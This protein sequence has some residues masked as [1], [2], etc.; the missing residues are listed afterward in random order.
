V[1]LVPGSSVAVDL[2]VTHTDAVLARPT[3]MTF[4]AA[5][6]LAVTLPVLRMCVVP[7]GHLPCDGAFL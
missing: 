5:P 6:V 7:A 2:L 4:A 3:L 1:Y